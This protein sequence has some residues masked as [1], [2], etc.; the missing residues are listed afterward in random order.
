MS[1]TDS[2]PDTGHAGHHHAKR[3]QSTPGKV[4]AKKGLLAGLG[5]GLACVVACSLPLLLGAG[6]LA[7]ASSLPA[8]AEVVGPLTLAAVAVGAGWWLLRR[9]RAAADGC[10]C[11]CGGGC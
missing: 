5:V 8:G 2:T 11:G 4:T 6:V 7:G 9:R 1:T 3:N 10:G